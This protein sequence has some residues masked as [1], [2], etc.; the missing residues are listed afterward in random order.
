MYKHPS[1]RETNSQ[2]QLS[3]SPQD[4][5]YENEIRRK[6]EREIILEESPSLTKKGSRSKLAAE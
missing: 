6:F 3:K 1:L 5:K 2:T 4:K